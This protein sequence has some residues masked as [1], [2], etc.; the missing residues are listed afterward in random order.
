MSDEV[1][2][3]TP[4]APGEAPDEIEGVSLEVG[5]RRRQDHVEQPQ[6]R[7][8]HRLPHQPDVRGRCPMA[9][10]G[11]TLRTPHH[12]TTEFIDF[13][14][15]G[16]REHVRLHDQPRRTSTASVRTRIAARI[17]V[18][19]KPSLDD[20]AGASHRRCAVGSDRGERGGEP[21]RGRPQGRRHVGHAR[22][23]R[24]RHGLGDHPL[25]RGQ[26]CQP[27]PHADRRPR[28][29]AR[30][31]RG[32]RRGPLH[33]LLLHRPRRQPARPRPLLPTRHRHHRPAASNRNPT[34]T[35]AR[36]SVGG[37]SLASRM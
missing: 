4:D 8:D 11:S 5:R 35:H 33:H 14:G 25:G 28:P 6:R 2:I 16:G 9:A 19:G 37:V 15:S 21:R 26:R 10:T 30:Q 23:G 36:R 29:H 7:H 24:G 32:A 22:L 20:D 12:S 18:V 31:A 34:R 3:T 17:T 13:H 1:T 27:R